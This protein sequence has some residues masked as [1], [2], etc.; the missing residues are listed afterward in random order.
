MNS[1]DRGESSPHT[2]RRGAAERQEGDL[3]TKSEDDRE[4]WAACTL[5]WRELKLAGLD[6]GCWGGASGDRPGLR[7]PRPGLTSQLCWLATCYK[8][9]HLLFSDFSFLNHKKWILNQSMLGITQGE[10]SRWDV[11]FSH[12]QDVHR[13][14]K[15]S[16]S[17]VCP[18]QKEW[19]YSNCH[20]DS[21]KKKK[22]KK[23]GIN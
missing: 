18:S 4:S 7:C 21:K 20:S 9:S 16:K 6:H 5:R 23:T 22:K 10:Q 12:Y 13:A 17:H 19:A 15:S 11:G 14:P 3:K 2:F 8:T 1:A